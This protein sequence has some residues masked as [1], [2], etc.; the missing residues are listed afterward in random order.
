MSRLLAKGGFEVYGITR[1]L[2]EKADK[3]AEAEGW[4]GNA[5]WKGW[6]AADQDKPETLLAAVAG[7]DTVFIVTNFWEHL[8]GPREERQGKAAIDAA[9]AAGVKQVRSQSLSFSVKIRCVQ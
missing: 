4:T 6:R 8:D 3:K 1:S 5:G 9:V 2:G 7:A